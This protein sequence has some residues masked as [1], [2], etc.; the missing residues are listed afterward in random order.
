MD[1][2]PQGGADAA[3]DPLPYVR[4]LFQLIPEGRWPA[5]RRLVH[6]L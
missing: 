1:R 6:L 3:A 2:S 5:P 4:G